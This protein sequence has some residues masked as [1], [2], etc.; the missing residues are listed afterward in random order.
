MTMIRYFT[1][2]LLSATLAAT[3][4]LATDDVQDYS[5]AER[6][7]F[8]TNHL[9][10][11]TAPTTLHYTFRKSGSLEEGFE[12]HVSIDLKPQ[13]DGSCCIGSGAFLTDARRISVPDVEDASGNPVILYFL[14]NDV[15]NMQ[16]LTTGQPNHFRKRI[17]MA[18]Y[19]DASVQE[20][21]VRYQGKDITVTEIAVDPYR[22]DPNRARFEKF[23]R[24]TYL[25]ELSDAVP[26]GVYSIRS[27]MSAADETTPPLILEELLV[28]GAESP[29]AS[30]AAS[31]EI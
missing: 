28:D 31:K 27:R 29:G 6:M 4:V 21:L 10:G 8:M 15:R 5:P 3:P 11:I 20:R 16:R 22:D 25:F 26:G 12:D 19:N 13:A 1:L 2:A 9:A 18:V 14:E 24:K 30:T 23:A 7:L 17:R